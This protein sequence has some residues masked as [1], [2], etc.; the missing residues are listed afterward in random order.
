MYNVQCT[1]WRYSALLLPDV[2]IIWIWIWMEDHAILFV[3]MFNSC[4]LDPVYIFC[5]G[6]AWNVNTKSNKITHSQSMIDVKGDYIIT[7]TRGHHSNYKPTNK[8]MMAFIVAH[9]TFF[10]SRSWLDIVIE[11]TQH[12]YWTRLRRKLK[13]E[14]YLLTVDS[15]M[16]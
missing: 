7:K 15:K 3:L 14:Y 11:L 12:E 16:S 4:D 8:F 6:V 10:W 13:C 2:E 1:N 5:Q 9:C